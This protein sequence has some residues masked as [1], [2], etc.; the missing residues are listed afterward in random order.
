MD[1]KINV[2]VIAMLIAGILTLVISVLYFNT[3]S[4][5]IESPK[6]GGHYILPTPHAISTLNPRKAIWV[7]EKNSLM[8][9]FDPMINLEDINKTRATLCE[10]W[11]LSPD[12]KHFECILRSG[13]LFH[14][15]KI[16]TVDDIVF[17]LNF[18]LKAGGLDVGDY[19]DIVGIEE[20]WKGEYA[21]IPGI[22][23]VDERTVRIDL[24]RSVPMFLSI[25]ASPRIVGIPDQ[26][27]GMAED[28]YFKRP[29]GTGPFKASEYKEDRLVV[30]ANEDYFNERPYLDKIE[31]VLMNND[32]AVEQFKKRKIH[33]LRYYYFTFDFGGVDHARYIPSEGDLN[34]L[35][36]PNNSAKPFNSKIY[37]E[38]LFSLFDIRNTLRKCNA[39][40]SYADSIIP[41]GIAGYEEGAINNKYDLIMAT[42]LIR[43]LKVNGADYKPIVVYYASAGDLKDCIANQVN[44]N[45]DTVKI[46]WR[47]VPTTFEK[48]AD[49]FFSREMIAEYEGITVK[50]D[51]AY[52]I[53]KYFISS[54]EENLARIDDKMIDNMLEKATETDDPYEKV[55]LYK[56]IVRRIIDNAYAFPIYES[57]N[58]IVFD[59]SV[60]FESGSVDSK[61]L[62]NYAK[63]WL[64]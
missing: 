64:K 38:L 3:Q 18:I 21:S 25:L 9:I 11:F 58:T 26:F 43:Q 36:F 13:V 31:M 29:I 53:L 57:G 63:V 35:L 51:D 24:S 33:E 54:N 55:Q 17:S 19:K 42:E 27:A 50:N 12:E 6:Y 16:M 40:D 14:N 39:L 7:S 60:H 4:D 34:V 48:L 15:N 8:F 1:K 62:V 45:F 56:K 44:K 59:K 10:S 28:E 41:S 37:R 61:Y 20:Y 49:L 5:S 46:P 32:E 30:V 2:L 52:S 47:V 22:Y 23:S